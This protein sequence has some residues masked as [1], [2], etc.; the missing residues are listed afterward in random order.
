LRN[1]A[2]GPS[3]SVLYGSLMNDL[4]RHKADLHQKQRG[5][6]RLLN[7]WDPIGVMSGEGAPSDEY[8]CLFGVLGQLHKGASREQRAAYLSEQLLHHFDLDP[9]GRGQTYSQAISLTGIGPIRSLAAFLHRDAR[10]GPED[11]VL[12][13]WPSTRDVASG[14]RDPWRRSGLASDGNR[15]PPPVSRIKN[16]RQ[17]PSR[18][19]IKVS[20]ASQT[21]AST[22]K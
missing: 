1:E 3:W 16:R 17:S 6:R 10:K 9:T 5:L 21:T 15:H 11:R 20:G 7:E 12:A 4:S 2:S 19:Q 13:P 14:E 8:D 22:M 18:R